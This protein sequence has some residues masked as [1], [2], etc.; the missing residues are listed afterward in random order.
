[1]KKTLLGLMLVGII[2]G[3]QVGSAW[4]QRSGV[5][6]GEGDF[7]I[8]VS[9]STIVKSAPCVWV[10]IHTDVPC[11]LPDDVMATVNDSDIDVAS[12]YADS[13]GNL[14]AKLNFD[15]VVLLAEDSESATISLILVVGDDTLM[16]SETVRVED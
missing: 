3:L 11:G 9:P 4:S 15:D 7:A 14:V 12:V 16:A 10:T 5:D 8:Y 2:L 13:R 6:G 1:M